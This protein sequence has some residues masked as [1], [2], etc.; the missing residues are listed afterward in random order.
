MYSFN[1]PK[2]WL[3]IK[4]EIILPIQACLL[5]GLLFSAL[6]N[7]LGVTTTTLWPGTDIFLLIVCVVYFGRRLN[8]I[9]AKTHGHRLDSL[10]RTQGSGL[11]IAS[12]IKLLT[13]VP[14]ILFF[15]QGLGRQ[16]AI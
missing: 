3:G 7:Y 4:S 6:T 11:V 5:C 13:Q 1:F 8:Q 15:G 9:I 2:R 14:I 16:L 10:L 12:A